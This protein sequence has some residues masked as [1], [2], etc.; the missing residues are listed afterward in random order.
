MTFKKTGTSWIM[1]HKNYKAYIG[2]HYG[3]WSTTYCVTIDIETFDGEYYEIKRLVNEEQ[4]YSLNE[5]KRYAK[6]YIASRM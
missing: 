1:N 6:E 2:R 5:S 3:A 4:F